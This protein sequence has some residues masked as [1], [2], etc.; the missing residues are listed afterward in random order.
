MPYDPLGDEQKQFSLEEFIAVAKEEL[1]GYQKVFGNPKNEFHSQP[2]T[3]QEWWNA[4]HRFM[5]W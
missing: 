4:F 1:D 2:H 5:S 3:W